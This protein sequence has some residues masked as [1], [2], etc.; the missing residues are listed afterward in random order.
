MRREVR[1]KQKEEEKKKPGCFV[2]SAITT[3]FVIGAVNFLWPDTIPFKFMEFWFIKGSLWEPLKHSW[4][5]FLWGAGL[6]TVH[7]V[8]TRNKPEDN[9]NAEG[10][11]LH[12]TAR[13]IFAGVMEEICFRWI[14]FYGAIIS[15]TFVNWLFFG[16]LGF[17]IPHFFYTKL[18]IPVANLTTLGILKPILYSSH[19]WIVGAAVISCNG[20]FRDGHSYQGWFGWINSWFAGMFLFYIMFTY[21]LPAAILVHFLYDFLIDIVMYVDHAAERAMGWR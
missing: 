16:W 12:G 13:S 10:I 15:L 20:R 7:A 4:I 2:T 19:G 21:G 5:F 11:A 17:G 14:L 9:R 8:L 18:L 1:K 6:T 3:L